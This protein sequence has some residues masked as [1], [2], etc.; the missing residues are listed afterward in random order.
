M[1]DVRDK[2]PNLQKVYDH[3]YYTAKKC[4]SEAR[5]LQTQAEIYEDCALR[6]EMA[7]EESS[8]GDK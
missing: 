8:Q 1:L 7:M 5:T 4:R 2:F 3:M 6:I